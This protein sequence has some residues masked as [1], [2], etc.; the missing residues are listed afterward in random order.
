MAQKCS[1]SDDPA[2]IGVFHKDVFLFIHVT[3]DNFK[4]KNLTEF[5]ENKLK[6]VGTIF[7]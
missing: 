4:E 1:N 5:Q 3:E 7:W 6:N 2:E